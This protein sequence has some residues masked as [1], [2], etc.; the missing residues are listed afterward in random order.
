MLRRRSA[1]GAGRG[2]GRSPCPPRPPRRHPAA[3]GAQPHAGAAGG[4]APVEP[5]VRAAAGGARVPAEPT[6][7]PPAF[8]VQAPRGRDAPGSGAGTG[9]SAGTRAGIGPLAP[10]PPR[11][12]AGAAK[13]TRTA[14]V[15]SSWGSPPPAPGGGKVLAQDPVPL[16]QAPPLLSLPSRR[17]SSPAAPGGCP[18]RAGGCPSRAG[19]PL[20]SVAPNHVQDT[21]LPP[22]RSG[23]VGPFDWGHKRAEAATPPGV[24]FS[25]LKFGN[26]VSERC[27]RRAPAAPGHLQPGGQWQLSLRKM[28]DRD[29]TA[30][31]SVPGHPV[32]PDSLLCSAGLSRDI[33]TQATIC[34]G[35]SL[36]LSWM[37]PRCYI[38]LTL[39]GGAAPRSR[40]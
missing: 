17:V 10:S 12:R 11:S 28:R 2:A 15:R 21:R 20:Q 34:S 3:R 37:L 14:P 25:L 5:G 26:M 22:L 19:Q 8:G 35:A 29:R 24:R 7:S 32:T 38:E 23:M 33:L 31:W 4:L 40:G 30:P 16:R 13:R 1:A 9:S 36:A 27:L 6:G 39:R 18:S